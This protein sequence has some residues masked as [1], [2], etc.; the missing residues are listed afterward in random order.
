MTRVIENPLV[1][2]IGHPTS[3]R[4]LLRQRTALP[5]E[6]LIALAAEHDVVLEVNANAERLDL[7]SVHAR[8]ALAAGV[9]LT[10]NT[11][12]HQ[13]GTLDNREHGVA[14]ARRAGA[15]VRDVVNCLSA[16][17]L[18]AGRRRHRT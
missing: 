16:D 3:R 18:L 1:D 14:V 12:A 5:I 6:T 17:Q 9:R 11:D 10:I 13:T 8:L 7:D 2:A 4:I 15:R